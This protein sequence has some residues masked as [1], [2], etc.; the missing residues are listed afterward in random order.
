M[1]NKF[2]LLSF[3]AFFAI[4]SVKTSGQAPATDSLMLLFHN[5]LAVFPQEK[6]HLHIDKPHYILGERIWLRAYVVDAVT[7]IPSPVSRYVYVELVNSDNSIVARVKIRNEE[8]A[9]HG[10]MF[11]PDDIPEG[12]YTI[13]AYTTFMLS[14]DEHYF[15]SRNIRISD[16]QAGDVFEQAPETNEDFEVLFFPEGGQ[17]M[18]GTSC[19]IAFKAVSSNGLHTN[20][21]GN[22][23]D[24]D[25]NEIS[26]FKSDHIGM[27]NFTHLAQKGKSY[28]VVCQNENGRTKRFN[29][30]AA[31]DYGYSLSVSQVRNRIY[32]SV[33]KPAE[34]IQN[35]VLYILAHTRGVPHFASLWDHNTNMILIQRE[36]FPTG[37][38]HFVLFDAD[39]KPVSERLMFINNKDDMTIV[40]Y[41]TDR[42]EFAARSLVQNRV[43]ITDMEGIPLTGNFSVSV[44][45]NREVSPD[46][47]TNILTNLLLTSDLRGFVENPAYY[48]QNTTA[49]DYAL[50]LLM[51]TQGWR[52]YDIAELAQGRFARPT[53]PLE[54]G[55]EITGTV[56]SVLLGRP[57]EDIQVNIFSHDGSYFDLTQTDSDG[58]FYFHGGE[59]VDSTRFVISAVPSRGMTRMEVL[60]DEQNFA[61]RT[62]PS[63]VPSYLVD[64]MLM[65]RYIEKADRQ[66]VS[67]F[68]IR[69]Y[70]L[71]ELTFTAERRQPRRSALYS[72]PNR[73]VTE[74]ELDRFPATDLRSV[75]IRMGVRVSGNEISI[76]G[77]GQPLLV[78]D[79]VPM[80]IDYIDM[81]N[82]Y[83]VAQVD[84]LSDAGNTA[85]FGTR[86]GNGV[87][88]VFTKDGRFTPSTPIRFHIKT[89]MPLGY[90]EPIEFY[91]PQYDTPENRNSSDPDLRTTIHWQPVV[92]T[93]SIGVATF[94]FYTADEVTSYTVIIEGLTNDGMII[95][96]EGQLWRRD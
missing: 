73:S 81:I 40:D 43:E 65:A 95:R 52:R 87:I 48:F 6:I 16:P 21:T 75:L 54:I 25:G 68:G 5:Q 62:L 37:V 44:T 31:I 76:R 42:E 24:Q 8:D 88:V 26:E 60:V 34:N 36:Q 71:E 53:S 30:P 9:Y 57:V 91:A 32:I 86:G 33:L 78:V 46:T 49:S 61:D 2:L 64:R 22:V 12:Y 55:P 29:L 7:H 39:F 50:D 80:E 17:L 92:Q 96:Q 1:K 14:L 47:T 19:R 77:G 69:T 3:F 93:D 45:S 67:E 38:L 51:R 90:Q 56:K 58:R 83:D 4:F 63:V 10:F 82:I 84:I 28:Y 15:F 18:M 70:Q 94:E 35:D 66:F 23:F 27:G 85:I 59:M 11:V 74:E 41:Q 13:R 89:V 72:S 20:I 79:D